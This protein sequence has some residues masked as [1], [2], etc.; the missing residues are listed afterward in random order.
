MMLEILIALA[1]TTS[2]VPTQKPASIGDPKASK[3]SISQADKVANAKLS[4]EQFD[5]EGALPSTWRQLQARGCQR[6]AIEAVQDYA[7]RGPALEPRQQRI[8]LFHLGQSLAML[9]EERQAATFIGLTREPPGSRPPENTLN[10]NDYV[11]GTWAFLVKDRALL[12]S[13]RDAVLSKP[14]Q[15]NQING[16][17]LAGLERCFDKP[18]AEAYNP[19]C[20][21]KGK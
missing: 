14:G 13:A 18:Y 17:I 4:F 20:Y 1:T 19:K 2:A 7:A 15:G 16:R 21:P 9:G 3:C 8:V 10:W 5:Q 12:A 6:E 11:T